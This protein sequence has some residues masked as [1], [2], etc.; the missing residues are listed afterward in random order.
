MGFMLCCTEEPTVLQKVT[1]G[2]MRLLTIAA[3]FGQQQ[4]WTQ[5]MPAAGST[6]EPA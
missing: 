4:S 5:S 3:S 2:T 6:Q 1:P